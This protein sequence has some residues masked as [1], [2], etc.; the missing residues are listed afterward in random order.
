MLPRRIRNILF[1]RMSVK[2][3]RYV[4]SVPMPK[5]NGL[6][7]KVYTM[8]ERD[9][10][11]NGSITSQSKV[12]ELMAGFW[13]GGRET[14]LVSDRLDRAT[15]EAM[16]GTLSYLNDCSYC[17]DMFVSLVHGSGASQT[18]TG[19]MFA[20]EETIKDEL[21]RSRL[22]WVRDATLRNEADI[23]DPPFDER[24]LPEAIATLFVASYVNRFSHVVMGGS[25][26]GPLF[27]SQKVKDL[28][29]RMFGV[30]LHVTTRQN[31]NPGDALT[32]LPEAPLPH[33]FDWAQP[34]P[35]IAAA[36]ARW[37]GAIERQTP[38]AVS[39]TV[40]NIVEKSLEEWQGERMPLSRS[41]VDG[42]VEGLDG[43]ERAVARLALVM[44]KASYHFDDSLVQDLLAYGADEPKLIRILAWASFLGAR[45][46]AACTADTL[47]FH[48]MQEKAAA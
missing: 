20:N 18:A 24:Q 7:R 28:M 5:A 23:V 22:L 38:F 36:Y 4:K 8:V 40:R 14:L 46:V 39:N 15:K 35:R 32:L 25:P 42:E 45:R 27:G 37:S 41:W 16:G 11:I 19:I 29:L 47:G 31:L 30:E 10:F 17:A 44:A 12:P 43:E 33:D 13:T 26:V 9:F 34:N 6:I 1:D 21:L 48:P 3:M 2:T